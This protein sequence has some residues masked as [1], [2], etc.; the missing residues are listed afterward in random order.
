M[1]EALDAIRV[2]YASER[3]GQQIRATHPYGYRCG[4]WGRILGV[5]ATR[6]RV[7]YMVAWDDEDHDLWPVEDPDD[8]YEFGGT[9]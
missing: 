8:P 5:T 3:I 4:E 6:D 7:C 2:A 1:R 9:A